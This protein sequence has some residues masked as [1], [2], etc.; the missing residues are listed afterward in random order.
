M[1]NGD[2]FG[3]EMD[4]NKAADDILNSPDRRVLV[5]PLAGRDA[6]VDY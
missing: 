3:V 4:V 6:V 1:M 2:S 5:E